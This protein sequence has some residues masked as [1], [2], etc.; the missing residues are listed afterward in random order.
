MQYAD[1][2]L[3]TSLSK[4]IE[5]DNPSVRRYGQEKHWTDTNRAI[6]RIVHQ[7]LETVSM[8]SSTFTKA[9]SQ[10]SPKNQ[11]NLSSSDLEPNEDV[12]IF[13]SQNINHKVNRTF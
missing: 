10:L 7:E 12:N 11:T 1:T 4:T 9:R 8:S 2:A 6:K 5:N 3:C 13:F